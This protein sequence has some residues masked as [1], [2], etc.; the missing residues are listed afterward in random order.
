MARPLGTDLEIMCSSCQ[1]AV[2]RTE[3]PDT[4]EVTVPIDDPATGARVHATL[5]RDV[6]S[7]H[8]H[9]ID[10]LAV[11]D[12]HGIPV[13]RD[14]DTSARAHRARQVVADQSIRGHP[15]IC[16]SEIVAEVGRL[17]QSVSHISSAPSPIQRVG[18]EVVE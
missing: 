16:P 18:G 2:G 3:I 6:S 9:S 7:G 12:A 1:M 13:I 8:T 5:V 15:A 17:K 4:L 10:L 11:T 14:A